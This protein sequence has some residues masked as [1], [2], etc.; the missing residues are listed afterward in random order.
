MTTNVLAR[1]IRR[2]KPAIIRE[3]GAPR[4]VILDWDTYEAWEELREDLEDAARL[5]AALADP[6]NQRRIPLSR[7]IKQFKSK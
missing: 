1:A 5:N 6:K 7:A 2:K 3:R 4:Y